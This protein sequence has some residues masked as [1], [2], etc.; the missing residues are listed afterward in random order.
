MSEQPQKRALRC[1]RCGRTVELCACCDEPDCD[2][3]LCGPCLRDLVAADLG[4]LEYLHGGAS[5]ALEVEENPTP[6]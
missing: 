5:A 1:V 2:P 6:A 4:R 3:P